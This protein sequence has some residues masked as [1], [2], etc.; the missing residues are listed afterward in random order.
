MP[1]AKPVNGSV[2]V[3]I[4]HKSPPPNSAVTATGSGAVNVAPVRVEHQDMAN[5]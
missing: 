4:T 3:N 2:D 5:I 1:G